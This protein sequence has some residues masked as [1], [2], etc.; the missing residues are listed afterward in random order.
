MP[1]REDTTSAPVVGPETSAAPERD[2]G[3][4]GT[5]SGVS[6][7]PGADS[8][9]V[10]DGAGDRVE[11]Q[12]EAGTGDE[13]DGDDEPDGDRDEDRG[14]REAARRRRELREARAERDRLAAVVERFQRRDVEAF[15]TEKLVDAADVWRDGL[16]LPDVLDDDG[17]VDA[18]KLAA[19]VDA[20]VQA[21]P[22]WAVDHGDFRRH[23]GGGRGSAPTPEGVGTRALGAALA[24]AAGRAPT[25]R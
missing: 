3:A 12:D 1:E 14:H 9:P 2:G 23:G 24:A 20:L 22:H 16:T 15:V 6:G 25:R 11:A 21:H 13:S 5:G 19:A 8:G 10:E 18:V 7:A 17:D 4:A